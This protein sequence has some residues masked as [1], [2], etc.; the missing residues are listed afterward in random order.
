MSEPTVYL[1]HNAT[2]PVRPEVIEAMLPYLRGEF[3]NPNSVHRLGQRA[4]KAVEAAREKVAALLGAGDAQEIVFTSCGSESDVLAISGAAWQAF[5]ESHGKRNRVVASRVEHDAVRGILGQLYRR[6]FKVAEVVCDGAGSV[7]V[8]AVAAAID[9]ATSVVSV[10]HANNEVG[11]LQPIEA[12]ARA[13]REKGALFH[14]DAVQSRARSR[15]RPGNG[16]SIFWRF[17]A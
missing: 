14:T 7:S 9:E 8:D 11:T 3:G 15:S 12:I 1:D 6:G 13:C 17:R 10:M 2:T 4:R 5:D 16:G